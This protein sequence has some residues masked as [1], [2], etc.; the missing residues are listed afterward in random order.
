MLLDEA[1]ITTR[2][3]C[4]VPANMEITPSFLLCLRGI[5]ADLDVK[6]P[7]H[8]RAP[9]AKPSRL[10]QITTALSEARTYHCSASDWFRWQR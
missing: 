8:V 9:F 6:E 7:F 3:V 4:L 1:M 2:G 10:L 5:G